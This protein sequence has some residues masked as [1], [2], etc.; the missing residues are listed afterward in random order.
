MAIMN[1][2]RFQGSIC[3]ESMVFSLPKMYAAIT[4]LGLCW[5]LYKYIT[6]ARVPK[7]PKATVT[8]LTHPGTGDCLI[9]VY[10]LALWTV[11]LVPRSALVLF[12]GH[13]FKM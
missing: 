6:V 12:D 5:Q 10:F 7:M 8:D 11:V 3:C 2:P 4:S 1:N 9:T 13:V